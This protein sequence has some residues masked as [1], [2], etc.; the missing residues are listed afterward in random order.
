V[1]THQRK[2]SLVKLI[3]KPIKTQST[4]RGHLL[5]NRSLQLCK[6]ERSLEA[7]SL[8][9]REAREAHEKLPKSSLIFDKR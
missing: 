4:A 6:G 8:L 3:R 7:L 1:R 2:S 9:P 5:N